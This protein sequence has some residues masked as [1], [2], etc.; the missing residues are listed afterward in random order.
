MVVVGAGLSGLF[1]ASELIDSGV[2][3]VVVVDKEPE[4][5]GVVR[6][7]TRDG[8]SL[9]PAAGSMMLPHPHLSPIL[10]R[11]GA[12]TTP[13]D[14]SASLRYVYTGDRL[15]PV[16]ASPKAITVPLLPP[17]AKLRALL[18]PL[19]GGVPDPDHESLDA[20]CRRRFGR[21]AGELLAWLMA[22]GVFAGDPRQLSARSAFPALAMMEK[23]DGSILRGVLRR[24]RARPAGQPRPTTHVPVG[25]MG[26]VARGAASMLGERLRTGFEVGTVRLRHDTWMVEGA[27]TLEADAV[28]VSCRPE[29][30]SRL[31][32]GELSAHLS[33]AT[34]APVVVVGLGGRGEPSPIPPG[35]GVLSAPGSGLASVGML[36]ESAYAPHRAPPG[37]WLV[38]VIAAG[39][40]RREVVDWDDERLVERVGGELAQVVGADLDATFV[41]VIRHRPGIPQYEIGH[42][43]WLELV[44][45]LLSEQPGLYLTGWG[46]RGV[47]VAQL[48]SEAVAVS[49]RIA[50]QGR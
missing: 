3:D 25:G 6:T 30:A 5:G 34:A 27:E 4:P 9:E 14:P 35:F 44:E 45:S 38:K 7:V 21:R 2:G 12:A 26:E 33:K 17:G 15:V 11:F 20:F 49:K 48:A 39:A 28:V 22:S 50:A 40:A 23:E 18:E 43:E 24:R 37:S 42:G 41:E 31:V 36:F 19:V 13:A 10:A 46:Y 29:L 16:P 8:F 32:T 47:G 1:I